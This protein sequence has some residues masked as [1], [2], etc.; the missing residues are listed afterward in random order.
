VGAGQSAIESAALLHETGAEVEVVSRR[1][2]N[3][4]QPDRIGQ[5]GLVER[6][7]APQNG[8]A[9]GWINWLLERQP[10]LFHRLPQPRKDRHNSHWGPTASDWLRPRVH[11]F[12]GGPR[13]HENRTIDSVSMGNGH[14]VA[15]LSGGVT[16]T[17]DHLLMATGYGVDLNRLHM[18][19]PSLRGAI[20]TDR[21]APVLNPWFQST[22]PG[23]YF[24]GFSSVRSFGPLYRFVA[25]CP[26]AARRVSASI[27]AALKP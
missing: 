19:D 18:I 26:A 13:L 16:A 24:V 9:P 11:A 27:A 14:I 15:T 22:A 5:R 21:G 7:C 2:I 10:Y 8:L 1:P 3:W 4:L 6:L 17:A 20:R 23:L 25:G 12:G